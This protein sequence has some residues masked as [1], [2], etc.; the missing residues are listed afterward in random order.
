METNLSPVR[1]YGDALLPHTESDGCPGVH[2]DTATP[3]TE[4]VDKGC[5]GYSTTTPTGIPA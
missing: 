4:E 5:H 2:G 3:D 1:A